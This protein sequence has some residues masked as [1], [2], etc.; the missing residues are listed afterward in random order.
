MTAIDLRTNTM[1]LLE[2][3]DYTDVVLWQKV[4]DA[5]VSIYN[6]E[7]VA[8]SAKRAQQKAKLRQMVGILDNA[9]DDC[10]RVKEE[11]LTEKH[12]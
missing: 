10:K 8:L 4:H 11:A 7:E 3:F 1:Q 2:R 12:Q 9:C 6:D 5:I